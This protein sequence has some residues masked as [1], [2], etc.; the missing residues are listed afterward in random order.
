MSVN[1]VPGD[2]TPGKEHPPALMVKL[3]AGALPP[4]SLITCLTTVSRPGKGSVPEAAGVPVTPKF[5]K[6]ALLELAPTS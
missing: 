6:L 2:S 1:V 4:L 5:V 3:E